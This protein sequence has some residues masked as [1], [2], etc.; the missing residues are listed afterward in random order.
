M[1]H[2]IKLVRRDDY[3]TN[4]KDAFFQI[5]YLYY[6]F[7]NAYRKDPALKGK[8]F[9]IPELLTYA[10]LWAYFIRLPLAIRI[11]PQQGN[12]IQRSAMMSSSV[13][14]QRYWGRL[15]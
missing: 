4:V 13:Q 8:V 3:F 7:V 11:S 5:R 14:V 2:E 9:A 15:Q 1:I 12:A 6:D 10:G